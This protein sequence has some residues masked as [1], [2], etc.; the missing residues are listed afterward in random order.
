MGVVDVD[1]FIMGI[2]QATGA[3][4]SVKIAA[5]AALIATS[6]NNAAKGIYAFSLADRKTGIQSLVLL[7]MLAALGL[8][9]AFWLGF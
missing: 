6:S 2:T 4:A 5:L 9:P 7:L 3:L 1:P 8:V